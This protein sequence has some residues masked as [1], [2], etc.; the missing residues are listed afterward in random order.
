MKW[1]I[2]SVT[3]DSQHIEKQCEK[4]ER[5]VDSAHLLDFL[6]VGRYALDMTQIV[7]LLEPN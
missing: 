6:R 7:T 3:V 1:S 2:D 5:F 4:Q